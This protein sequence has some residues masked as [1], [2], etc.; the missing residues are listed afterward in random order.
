ME[1]DT[2]NKEQIK[3]ESDIDKLLRHFNEKDIPDNIINK[4]NKLHPV[5][6]IMN[7]LKTDQLEVGMIIKIVS[8]DLQKIFSTAIILQLI[9]T[10]SQKIGK[11]LLLNAAYNTLW[12]I[13]P[14]KYYIFQAEKGAITTHNFIN[15][16]KKSLGKN[17][18]F[19][20]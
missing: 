2:K 11:L 8:L 18:G 10:S 12:Y 3:R 4:I 7:F 17:N 5:T 14:N 15:E 16:F 19:R 13:N 9:P 6:K 20:N 1:H